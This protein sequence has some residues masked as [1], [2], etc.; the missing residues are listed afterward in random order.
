MG[1]SHSDRSRTS[2][3]KTQLY[4]HKPSLPFPLISL[5]CGAGGS[6]IN[7]FE[8]SIETS[9]LLPNEKYVHADDVDPKKQCLLA[10]FPTP[11][12]LDENGEIAFQEFLRE[13]PG[14][15]SLFLSDNSYTDV[16]L[17]IRISIDMDSRYASPN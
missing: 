6:S 2:G 3:A 13:Y 10:Y 8:P 15:S 9:K 7:S 5:G 16:I 14:E 11:A 12:D 1:N 4:T 17:F